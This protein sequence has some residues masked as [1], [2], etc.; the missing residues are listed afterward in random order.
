MSEYQIA[1]KIYEDSKIVLY[2][3]F[4]KQTK[5]PVIIKTL[6]ND[7]PAIADL[8]RLKQEYKLLANLECAGILKPHKL[9]PYGRNLAL[10]YEAFDGQPLSVFLKHHPLSLGEFLRLAIALAEVLIRLQEVGIVHQNINSS[11]IL[12]NRDRC[13]LKLIGFDR[14]IALTP[15]QRIVSSASL[16]AS[17]LAYISPEQT[18]RMNRSVDYRTDFYS[19]GVTFYEMLL[20]DLPFTSADP[21]ELIHAHIAKQPL[22][23]TSYQLSVNRE[24]IPQVVSDIV[25]KLMAKAAE[26]RYQTA[27]GLKFDLENCLN[28]LRS[29]NKI[30][31]FELGK[32]DLGK[33]LLLSEK[34]YGREAEIQTLLDA[35]ARVSRGRT[36]FALISGNS[37][38]GKTSIVNEVYKPISATRGYFIASK[39]DQFKRNIPY[40]GFV[41]AFQNLFAQLL[42]E[43]EAQIASWRTKLLAALAPNAQVIIDLIP[44]LE[45]IIGKQ[46]EVPQLGALSAQNRLNLAYEKLFGVFCQPEHPL[47]IFL[48]DLQWAD[49]TSLNLIELLSQQQQ[50][51][52]F[53][54]GVYRDN[55]VDATH[56]LMEAIAN[57]NSTGIDI[58]RLEIAPLKLI[59]VTAAIADNIGKGIANSKIEAFA[60]LIFRKTQGNPFFFN[61][62][63]KKL[64]AEKLLTYKA[65]SNLWQWDLGQ[66]Q[67]VGIS[68]ST[69][70]ELITSNLVRLPIKTR[71]ILKI[72]ACLGNDFDL[73]TIATIYQKSPTI[74]AQ[75][76]LPALEA[77]LI[78]PQSDNYQIPLLF[79][80]SEAIDLELNT[81]K[82]NYRF[83][84]DRIR[85]AAYN[86]I[87]EGEKPATHYQI[88]KIL[89]E[90]YNSSTE[91]DNLFAVVNQ[92]NF[93]RNLLDNQVEK[94]NLAELNLLAGQRAKRA[95]AYISARDYFNLATELLGVNC[96][97]DCYNLAS[98]IYLE[99]AEVEYLNTNFNRA[100]SCCDEGI[101]KAK[102]ILQKA[103]FYEIKI[104]LALAQNKIQSAI[105]IGRQTL[106][107][108]NINPTQSLPQELEPGKLA[109]L[110]A[111]SDPVMLQAMQ[112]LMLV[113][114]PACFAESSMALPILYT[115]VELSSQYGNAP[116]SIYAYAVYSN[117]KIWQKSDLNFAY[118]ISQLAWLILD[119]LKALE[120]QAK[121]SVII[122]INITHWKQPLVET[123]EPLYRA[124]QSGLEVGD[125]EFAC[126]AAH[127]Y[128]SHLFFSSKNLEQVQTSQIKYISLI[129]KYKQKH[130]LILAK[131]LAQVVENITDKN[132]RY[133]RLNGRFI[134]EKETRM[135]LKQNNNLLAIFSL[136]FAKYFTSYLFKDYPQALESARLGSKYSGFVKAEVIYTQHNFYYS[137]SVLAR[138]ETD[139]PQDLA[140]VEQN[141]ALMQYW[142]EHCPTNYQHKYDLVEAEKARVLGDM[143]IAMEYYDRAIGRAKEQGYI[144]EEAIS[145][146]RAAEF[147]LTIGRLEIGNFYLKNA[148]YCYSRWGATGKTR[149]LAAEYPHLSLDLAQKPNNNLQ[150]EMLDLASVIKATK[151][152]SREI[153]LEK[154]LTTLMTT[155]IENA[156]A[157]TGCLVLKENDRW[158][159]Q[160]EGK[161]NDEAVKIMQSLPIDSTVGK[162]QIPILPVSIINYVARTQENL[163]LHNATADKRF[164]SDRYI[165]HTQSKSIL[166]TPLLDRG[167]LSGILYLENNLT[168]NAFTSNRLEIVKII[169]SQ[170]ATS[171]QNAQL[172]IA[173]SQN[174]QRLTQFLEAVPVGVFVV[175]AMGKPYYANQTAQQILGKGIIAETTAEEL[176]K[177]YQAYLAGTDRLYPT[178]DQPVL[179]ALKGERATIDDVE[180]HQDNK[181]IP[182]EVSAMP[183]VDDKGKIIYAI[184]A[185]QDISD[186]K[187]VE[188]QRLQFT[189][190]LEQKVS[191]RTI[192]L[193]HTLEL[194]QATQAELMFE[195][196]LLRGE[197]PTNFDYQV[198]G[199]LP[200]DAPTY[201]VR[202]ADRQLYR[203]LKQGE[204]CYILNPRQMG[205]SSLMVRMIHHLNGEGDRCGAIDLTRIGSENLTPEQWYKGLVV[206]LWR[207]FGLL[208]KVNFKTWWQERDGLSAVQKLSQFIEEI[209]LVEVGETGTNIVIFIDEIDSLLSLNFS[210]NDFFALIRSCYNQRSL[211]PEYNRLT[212]A[213]FGV[214]T[215]HDLISDRQRTPFNI[216]RAIQLE[217]FKEHE[218][219][220]LLRGLTEV[221]NPQTV[222][223]EI[224]LWT[225]GQPFLT[226]KLCQLIRDTSSEI[227]ADCEQEWIANLVQTKIIQNWES[228]DE[229]EHLRTI[230]DRLLHSTQSDKL[231]EL[232]HRICQGEEI[233]AIDNPAQRELILSGL[234]I[235]QQGILKLH[236]PIYQAIS[237]DKRSL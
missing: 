114:P 118:K 167:K 39:F 210:V 237:F 59:D 236:N 20:G 25:M 204:F 231:L 187:Q 172:Y 45:L 163:V 200:M 85:E 66:I 179:R 49:L 161:A 94:D 54:I 60:R 202:Q 139:E 80:E 95:T 13:Q 109:E 63:L 126:Y 98:K 201:V 21:L 140:E 146:E 64:H 171:I 47:V 227:A 120:Y 215:P 105:E 211:N 33:Q 186:R 8:T 214:A 169:S 90:R 217:G 207:S 2:R 15:G 106:E 5:Q 196:E 194:L 131:I 223:K 229:P 29:N 56:A 164:N 46:P 189:Q 84:H 150:P 233:A 89:L 12:F 40:T 177:T 100:E 9:E 234:V 230:R 166:C 212:F 153:Q 30:D 175:D 3:G 149:A 103:R 86:S 138:L 155:A 174:K 185:F 41:L 67:G 232:Y 35:F 19:L 213:F 205:K 135:E 97:R 116:A 11:N 83:L 104:R 57:I 6:V 123:I 154:L 137:L 10:F 93:G 22:S 144:Q 206:E 235:K 191:E 180:I 70:V 27:A 87:A 26:E 107:L 132:Y 203:A 82:V 32:R 176:T 192:E 198:G 23:V 62:L 37:G 134:R 130:Q 28:Q 68:N 197:S 142:A 38:V 195:N 1:E 71:N 199:S 147:Y 222:L 193:S 102:N 220:P 190:Q 136:F 181:I 143:T 36:E 81:I 124:I 42:T 165:C 55:E 182:L 152:V 51:C 151:A 69:I 113:H 18:G 53:L 225:N 77:G 218:A 216:G 96:W 122:S 158:V 14:A 73:A 121:V 76:L 117:L 17:S 101:S 74:T 50:G 24:K 145:Y 31:N 156:G 157:Q 75:E 115:M 72:A 224:L 58:A 178:E 78:L 173:V 61:Q 112:V 159:I 221:A 79:N 228:Q 188:S 148:Y 52:L 208:G 65:E 119:K 43:T 88:G 183:V 184:A 128:C 127:Y 16:S 7:Y 92:L 133:N 168:T 141:Q 219:Q 226:Q 48:D 91:K 99:L 209:L 129:E 110:P 160:A 34:L 44:E 111:M 125:C 170:A 4:G 162:S 108:L